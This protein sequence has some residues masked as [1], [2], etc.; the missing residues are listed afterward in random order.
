MQKLTADQPQALPLCAARG[1]RAQ[2]KGRSVRA[3]RYRSRQ[4]AGL[5]SEDFAARQ[6]A[7]AACR[8]RGRRSG[9]V[10]EQCH[11]RVHRG[12]ARRRK[13][14]SAGSARS[15]RSI[16]PGWS[17]AR[18]FSSELW[19]LETTGDPAIFESKRQ[20]VAAKFAQV[21]KT[22]GAGPF[23]A[24]KDFS[25]V[26]AVFAPIFR[27]FDVFDQLID[28]SVFADTP[29]VRA[30]RTRTGAA[31]ECAHGGGRRLSAI[32]ARVPGAP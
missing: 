5:V 21:E 1:D 13:T 16:A 27:Y 10:R 30:W 3:D 7:G 25:L 20:A 22:L 15:A 31:A 19:G 29:K 28:L 24:G 8:D 14:A 6:G 11:L 4:Q 18:P 12:D 23:F 2:R 32:A 9:A 26:D 17:S